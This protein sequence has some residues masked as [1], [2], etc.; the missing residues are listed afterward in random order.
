MGIT[1]SGAGCSLIDYLYT[2]IDFDSDSFRRFVSATPGDGGLSPGKLVFSDQFEQFS[3]ISFQQALRDCTGN[4]DPAGMNLGGPAIVALINAGQILHDRDVQFRFH[5]MMAD[6]QTGRLIQDILKTLPVDIGNYRIVDGVTPTT[7]VLSDPSHHG[8]K[9]E[10]TFINSIGVAGRFGPEDLGADFYEAEIVL[11]GGTG[12]VPRLHDGLTEICRRARG[13]DCLTIVN[14]VFDFRSEM[15]DPVNRWPLGESDET[16]RHIN[17]L[18]VDQEEAMRMSGAG[19]ARESLLQFRDMGVDA[20][21]V[22]CGPENF[23]LYSGGKYFRDL[24]AAEFPVVHQVEQDIED[25]TAMKGDTTGCGDNFVGGVLASV[26]DQY[27]SESGIDLLEAASWGVASGGQACLY[28][29]GTFIE[30][31]PGEKRAL[32]ERYYRAYRRQIGR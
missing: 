10:R 11:L 22:T 27:G 16:Y 25:G 20:A 15:K 5:G 4:A 21:I 2:E 32:I 30:Q 18:I 6:D 12:L 29:G 24:D 9:G 19:T 31:S 8:G 23:H 26:A 14:T 13:S 3:G 7:V 17:L 1:I 28:V